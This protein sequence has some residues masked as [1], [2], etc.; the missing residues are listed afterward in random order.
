MAVFFLRSPFFSIA[1]MRFRRGRP[2]PFG[3]P[4]AERLSEWTAAAGVPRESYAQLKFMTNGAQNAAFESEKG[5][6]A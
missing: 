6:V 2:K 5:A 3:P 1:C 4:G